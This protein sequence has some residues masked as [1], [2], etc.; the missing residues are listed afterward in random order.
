MLITRNSGIALAF[1]ADPATPA[2]PAAAP[3]DPAAF[4]ENVPTT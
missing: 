2:D 4:G 1:A 3:D